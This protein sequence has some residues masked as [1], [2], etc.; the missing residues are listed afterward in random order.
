MVHANTLREYLKISR[1]A[2]RVHACKNEVI[3]ERYR[4]YLTYMYLSIVLG[5]ISI[6]WEYCDISLDN[7]S[8]H[9]YSWVSKLYFNIYHLYVC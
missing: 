5:N 2:T 1:G 3:I 6:F 4:T 9:G 8:Y 7:I